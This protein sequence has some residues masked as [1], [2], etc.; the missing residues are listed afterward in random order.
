NHVLML[1]SRR[2]MRWTWLGGVRVALPPGC[3]AG[4]LP[5]AV[6]HSAPPASCSGP[7]MS[8]GC[9]PEGVGGGGFG[10]T[11]WGAARPA[12]S[13]THRSG[14]APNGPAGRF[15]GK[16]AGGLVDR[17]AAWRVKYTPAG[18]KPAIWLLPS[19]LQSWRSLPPA[20]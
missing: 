2:S 12:G 14:P 8:G 20:T 17:L 15:V 4:A 13:T 1:P 5:P 9:G 6:V 10:P 11:R 19:P 18:P 3:S 7:P 16:L